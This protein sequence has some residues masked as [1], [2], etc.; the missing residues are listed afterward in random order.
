MLIYFLPFAFLLWY[1]KVFFSGAV[2]P[3]KNYGDFVF[4]VYWFPL[5]FGFFYA[6]KVGGNLP[7]PNIWAML[8]LC[9]AFSIYFFP[10]FRFQCRRE[11]AIDFIDRK[12]LAALC[13]ALILGGV[14]AVIIF[15]SKAGYALEYGVLAL[16]RGVYSGEVSVFNGNFIDTVAVGFSSFFGLSQLLAFLILATRVFGR[17]S[18]FIALGLLVSSLSYVFNALA[19]G[20]RDGV[21]FWILSFFFCYVLV[22]RYSTIRPPVAVRILFL[23]FVIFGGAVLIYITAQRF[24]DYF[25]GVFSYGAMQI[26]QFNAL[27]SIDPPLYHGWNSFGK[28]LSLLGFE[29]SIAPGAYK[30]YYLSHGVKPWEFKF[31]VGSLFRDFGKLGTVALL[32]SFAIGML[33]LFWKKTRFDRAGKVMPLER[34]LALYL[35]CQVG[36]MGVF[37]FKHS[38]LNMYLLAC[39]ILMGFFWVLRKSGVRFTVPFC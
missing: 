2:R 10:L 16:R 33:L 9:L 3:T 29:R 30:D 14:G 20:G 6:I 24:D 23:C 32:G 25:F 17:L 31:F 1:R 11:E 38:A 19:F 5:L 35:Y 21:V 39:L 4:F 36:F 37:Y 12:I 28:I 22:S 15:S 7:P 27:F 13:V 26:D 34:I 8:Y 18:L